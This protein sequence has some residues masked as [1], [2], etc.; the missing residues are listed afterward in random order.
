MFNLSAH[1]EEVKSRES[2]TTIPQRK[3]PVTSS[4]LTI[5]VLGVSEKCKC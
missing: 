3:L 2:G 4:S 5:D 1:Y